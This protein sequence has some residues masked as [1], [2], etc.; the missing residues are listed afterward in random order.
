MPDLTIVY[1]TSNREEPGFESRIQA[2]LVEHADGLPILSV[3]QQ[4]LAWGQNI[5]V[6]N[7][8]ASQENY[9]RQCRIGVAAANT[10]YVALVEADC[11][12]PPGYFDFRPAADDTIYYADEA[13]LLWAGHRSFWY[14]HMRELSGIADRQHLLRL[15][16]VLD[17]ERPKHL[18][19]LIP[20][21]TKQ[22]TF[23]TSAPIVSFKTGRGMHWR[24]PHIRRKVRELPLWGDARGL[25]AR[26]AGE[27]ACLT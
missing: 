16:D 10:K 7:I 6:G 18:F 24:S 14:K 19:D 26:F 4:P 11:L 3:S 17:H 5:C 2:A 22:A 20:S 25:W 23:P 1:C 8:G 15:L 12:Y 9:V 27:A 13:C 21:L